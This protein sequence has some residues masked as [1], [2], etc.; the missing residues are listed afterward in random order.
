L[1]GASN[2]NFYALNQNDGS[3]KWLYPAQNKLDNVAFSVV[4]DFDL[5]LLGYIT[6]SQPQ[7][8]VNYQAS[9]LSLSLADGKV[10]W[11]TPISN[12][13]ASPSVFAINLTL[14]TNRLLYITAFSDLYGVNADSGK[15]Q[16][17]NNF[18][19]WVLPPAYASGKLF[20]AADLK[21]IAYQ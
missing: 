14:T 16:V 1:F 4:P 8:A 3:L 19:Y 6:F 13:A 5:I 17:A 9:I 20:V 2:G 15:L 11:E 12:T 7:H 10:N 21:I 18:T